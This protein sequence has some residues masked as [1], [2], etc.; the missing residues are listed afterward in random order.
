MED[1]FT[2]S[3]AS[4][5]TD[6]APSPLHPTES[7]VSASKWK[8]DC[9]SQPSPK[10]TALM[11][12]DILSGLVLKTFLPV[13]H[14]FWIPGISLWSPVENTL[15]KPPSSCWVESEEVD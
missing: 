9:H 8:G 10:Q 5:Q 12:N 2:H 14:R 3:Q 13:S 1:S 7:W 4:S 15:P 11:G 6:R